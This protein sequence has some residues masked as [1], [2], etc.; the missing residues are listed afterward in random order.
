MRNKYPGKC[1][2]CGKIVEIGAG[3]FERYQG[4]FRV[5]HE[6]CMKKYK[7]ID[8]SSKITDSQYELLEERLSVKQ[9]LINGYANQAID[10]LKLQSKRLLKKSD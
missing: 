3:F 1:Y 4:K 8:E 6:Y 2:K 5:Q 9:Q 10:N 7:I